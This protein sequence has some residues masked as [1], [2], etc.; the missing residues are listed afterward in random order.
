MTDNLCQCLQCKA[1]NRAITSCKEEMDKIV[2]GYVIKPPT[3]QGDSEVWSSLQEERYDY[4]EGF[5]MKLKFIREYP[6][7]EIQV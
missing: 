4:L 6:E 1:L 3:Y 2:K 7:R 5:M